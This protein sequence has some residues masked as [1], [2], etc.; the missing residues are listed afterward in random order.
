MKEQ[1]LLPQPKEETKKTEEEKRADMLLAIQR[2]S[3]GKKAVLIAVVGEI[4]PGVTS[5]DS[6]APVP[7]EKRSKARNSKS[8][9]LYAAGGT[10]KTFSSVLRSLYWSCEVAK[11]CPLLR[12]LLPPHC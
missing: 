8:F 7:K 3:A 6:F 10:G 12:L 9:F 11:S 5:D 4:L 1:Q 2:F